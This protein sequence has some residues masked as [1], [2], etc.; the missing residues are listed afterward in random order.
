MAAPEI[1]VIVTDGDAK[2]LVIG[3]EFVEG[4]DLIADDLGDVPVIVIGAEGDRSYAAWRDASSPDA[5]RVPQHQE[6]VAYQLYSSGTTGRPKG[7]QL[8]QANLASGLDL[9]PTLMGFGPD[10]V[11]LVAMPL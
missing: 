1:A 7:V 2:V 4:L 5:P 10:S 9:Y 11:N 6:D 3:S 8:T